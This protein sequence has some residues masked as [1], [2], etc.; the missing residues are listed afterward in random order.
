MFLKKRKKEKKL[1]FISLFSY[2]LVQVLK[3]F[4]LTVSLPS[5]KKKNFKPKYSYSY[6]YS[7][8][9]LIHGCLTFLERHLG[10]KMQL[11]FLHYVI[12]I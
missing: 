1:C 10:L 11:Q 4:Y 5:L 6:L 12:K 7:F 3:G 8:V 2:C 9:S